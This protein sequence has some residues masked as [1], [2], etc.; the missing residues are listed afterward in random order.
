MN[1]LVA[2]VGELSQQ[3]QKASTIIQTQ[4]A[5]LGAAEVVEPE[6]GEKVE[7][8][9]ADVPDELYAHII[10]DEDKHTMYQ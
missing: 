1:D 4:D 5:A 8:E 7:G 10:K 6:P 9:P 2:M 3:V